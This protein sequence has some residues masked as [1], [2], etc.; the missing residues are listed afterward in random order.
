VEKSLDPSKVLGLEF[1]KD[2]EDEEVFSFS[3][4]NKYKTDIKNLKMSVMKL[5]TI[6]AQK[7]VKSEGIEVSLFNTK[8]IIFLTFRNETEQE[9][10]LPKKWL[11]K[12]QIWEEWL[13]T[14]QFL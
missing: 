3:T 8:L 11:K 13:Q 14:E 10:Q 5:S 9:V 6:D 7:K 1:F 2:D 4:V 12:K